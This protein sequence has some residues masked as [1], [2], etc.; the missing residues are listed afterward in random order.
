V[1]NVLVYYATLQVRGP[2]CLTGD[3]LVVLMRKIENNNISLSKKKLN[4]AIRE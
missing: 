1:T 2:K 3:A 4:T